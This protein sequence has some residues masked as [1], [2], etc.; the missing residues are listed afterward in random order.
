VYNQAERNT[1]RDF[2]A[3]IRRA[4]C[5]RTEK[6]RRT[7]KRIV[8]SGPLAAVTRT[9]VG[10][11][12]ADG[13]R[14][15]GMMLWSQPVARWH[16]YF[17]PPISTSMYVSGRAV[18][19]VT[20][21]SFKLRASLKLA[22]RCVHYTQWLACLILWARIS[23]MSFGTAREAT[24]SLCLGARLLHSSS[25]VSSVIIVSS[26]GL[27]SVRLIVILSLVSCSLCIRMV[28]SRLCGC[29]RIL[30]RSVRLVVVGA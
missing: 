26:V 14:C 18:F 25:P 6:P 13:M 30:R 29:S 12:S 7:L 24:T 5:R 10:C 22:F 20:T 8:I 27:S 9:D 11:I 17:P 21:F 3:S 28:W 1:V 2:L 15:L 19:H 23:P 16:M 4:F